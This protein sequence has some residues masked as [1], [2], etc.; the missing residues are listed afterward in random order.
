MFMGMVMDAGTFASAA[1][2][3]Y[4]AFAK[5]PTIRA[6]ELAARLS[7]SMEH[8]RNLIA[9][10]Q[11]IEFGKTNK[12]PYGSPILFHASVVD[13]LKRRVL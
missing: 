8:I 13:F 11:L 7:C 10:G 12:G 3:S 6:V 9:D 4:L 5:Q 1:F 2:P